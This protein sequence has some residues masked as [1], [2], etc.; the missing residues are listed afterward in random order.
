MIKTFRRNHEHS[1][2]DKFAKIVG[3]RYR[4]HLVLFTDIQ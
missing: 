2:S 1:N 3:T 4:E